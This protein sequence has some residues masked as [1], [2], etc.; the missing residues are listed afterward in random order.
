[1]VCSSITRLCT[2]KNRYDALVCSMCDISQTRVKR[3]STMV[4]MRYMEG[5]GR[6][7]IVPAVT[8][9]AL[10]LSGCSKEPTGDAMSPRPTPQPTTVQIKS[11]AS[12]TLYIE[13]NP[14]VGSLWTRVGS[15]A[16]GQTATA[17]CV[18]RTDPEYAPDGV[19]SVHIVSP[20]EGYIEPHA[21]YDWQGNG[22][23][24]VVEPDSTELS[25]R[26]PDCDSATVPTY[27][28]VPGASHLYTSPDVS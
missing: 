1:M 4:G 20:V 19:Q 16:A 8:V 22:G 2:L 14:V 27:G 17:V 18:V 9:G 28:P 15:L 26:L 24:L 3:S 21:P 12:W 25:R 23:E 5:L 10:V 6:R 13:D 7:I 11:I